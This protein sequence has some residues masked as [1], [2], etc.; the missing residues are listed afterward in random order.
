MLIA[1]ILGVIGTKYNQGYQIPSN[2]TKV[3]RSM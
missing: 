1:F 3:I 2:N